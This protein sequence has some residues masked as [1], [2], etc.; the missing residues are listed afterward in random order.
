MVGKVAYKLEL[1][2]TL[3]IHDVF[4]ISLL[5]LCKTSGKIQPPPPPI[6]EDDELSFDVEC[7]FTHEIRGSRTR[8]QNFYLIKWLGYGLEHNP[9]EPEKKLSLEVLKEYWDT[10]ARSHER[11]IQNKGVESVSASNKINRRSNHK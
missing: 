6:L 9:W 3:K 10:V 2:R 7:V 1:P 5:K 11:L 8:P 4:H